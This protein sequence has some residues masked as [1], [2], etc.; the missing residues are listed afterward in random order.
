MVQLDKKMHRY[1]EKK[2]LSIV[3]YIFMRFGEF[4]SYLNKT[5][6]KRPDEN[7]VFRRESFWNIHLFG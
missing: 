4:L 1:T 2:A 7:L 6:R 3:V 5:I